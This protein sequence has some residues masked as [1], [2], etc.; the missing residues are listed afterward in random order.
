MIR[1]PMQF[2]TIS[3]DQ[4]VNKLANVYLD[5][6]SIDFRRFRRQLKRNR[7]VRKFFFLNNVVSL[8][9]VAQWWSKSSQTVEEVKSEN[10]YIIH[11]SSCCPQLYHD[12]RLHHIIASESTTYDRIQF[13]H[14]HHR[15]EM[16]PRNL[17]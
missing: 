12:L 6:S 14:D 7:S 1:L 3:N 17:P 10:R 5:R 13:N 4:V 9:E 11:C 16:T 8:P 15:V 2:Q